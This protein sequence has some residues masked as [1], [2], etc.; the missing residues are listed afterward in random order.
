MLKEVCK[1]MPQS[2]MGRV[3]VINTY[4]PFWK[5]IGQSPSIL[6]VT[7]DCRRA[8]RFKEWL[9]AEGCRVFSVNIHNADDVLNSCRNILF[10][11]TVLN[12]DASEVSRSREM[13]ETLRSLYKN[14]MAVP[15][16][17][18]LP[19]VI[20]TD[21]EQVETTIERLAVRSVYHIP[22]SDSVKDIL[23]QTIEQIHYL[24]CRYA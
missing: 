13:Y 19:M 14:L 8:H 20:M 7:E 21:C 3:D 22:R 18:T 17:L 12:I 9:E 23:L 5:D 1:S 2:Q 4:R 6:L 24:T 10:D 16:L 15:A 11:I